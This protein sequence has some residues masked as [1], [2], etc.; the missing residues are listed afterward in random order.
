[1]IKKVELLA[2]AGNMEC[3]KTAL[4]FG[5]DAVYLAGKSYGLRAF[6]ANFDLEEIR[7]ACKT[8]HALN[9]KV[10][11]TVNALMKEDEL[12]GLRE[13]IIAL[14]DAGVFTQRLGLRTQ[15]R[16]PTLLIFT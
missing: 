4:H 11:V 3:F 10:Y 2:P 5:A 8:A 6:A 14:K 15:L 7:Y 9:K 1:M 12:N 16:F 13:Y